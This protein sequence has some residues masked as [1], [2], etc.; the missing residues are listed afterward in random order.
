[1]NTDIFDTISFLEHSQTDAMLTVSYQ[2]ALS[3][4][5]IRPGYPD[6][7][8]IFFYDTVVD[9]SLATSVLPGLGIYTKSKTVVTVAAT[10]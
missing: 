2:Y 7:I 5:L 10:K 1:M 9:T 6:D 8:T 4:N 3:P